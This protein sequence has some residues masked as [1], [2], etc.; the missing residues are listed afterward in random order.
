VQSS[1]AGHDEFFSCSIQLARCYN[2]ALSRRAVAC[3]SLLLGGHCSDVIVVSLFLL[4][5][6]VTYAHGYRRSL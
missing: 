6:T 4:A 5:A 1:G 2:F 3:L